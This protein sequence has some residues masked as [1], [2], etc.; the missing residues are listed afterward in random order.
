MEVMVS[1]VLSEVRATSSLT[2]LHLLV[3]LNWVNAFPV[4]SA[5]IGIEQLAPV[6]FHSRPDFVVSGFNVGS[7]L[8]SQTCLRDVY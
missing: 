3:R 4:D 2:H 5:R 6:V 7:E 8:A 1:D